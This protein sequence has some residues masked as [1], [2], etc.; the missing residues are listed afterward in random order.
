MPVD[1]PPFVVEDGRPGGLVLTCEHAGNALPSTLESFAPRALLDSH[2]G[3]DPGALALSRVLLARLGGRLVAG[4]YSRLW[5][6]L[7]R[8]GDDPACIPVVVDG[9]A[10]PAN[11][12]LPTDRRRRLADYHAPYHRAVG[13]TLQR[14]ATAA[15]HALLLSVHSFTPQLGD[16]QRTMEA[17]VLFDHHLELAG[18]VGRALER[19]GFVVA[20]N[21]PYS[22]YEGLIYS[23]KRHGEARELPYVELELRNDL[24]VPERLPEVALRVAVALRAALTGRVPLAADVE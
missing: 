8:P 21:A 12:L 18:A 17:G 19:Q 10:L 16:Q 15:G 5:V 7:N 1:P 13:E 23:A 3:W 20:D 22:G 2:R 14:S 4:R 11:Q 24:L 6:D 9:V